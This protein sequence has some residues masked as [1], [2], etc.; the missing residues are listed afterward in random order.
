MLGQTAQ[1]GSQSRR[2]PLQ[3]HVRDG[4]GHID[5]VGRAVTEHLVGD[6]DIPAT[7]IAS[8]RHVHAHEPASLSKGVQEQD[9]ATGN[10]SEFHFL[11]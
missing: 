9:A 1:Q 11:T 5:H 10:T 6:H 8:L 7:R 4:A 3:L 2:L